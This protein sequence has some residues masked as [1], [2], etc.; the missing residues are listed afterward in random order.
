[1]SSVG[2]LF[3]VFLRLGNTSFGGPVAHIA[4][5]RDEFVERRRWFD[6]AEFADLVALCH[7][8]PGPASSQVVIGIGLQRAGMAGALAASLGFT[9]PSLVLMIAFGYGLLAAGGGVEGAAWIHALKVV[10]SAVIAQAIWAMA[11][12]LCPDR[13]RATLAMAAATT[14]LVWPGSVTQLLVLGA[15]GLFGWRWCRMNGQSGPAATTAT[16]PS[17]MAL[18]SLLLFVLLLLASLLVPWQDGGGPALSAAMFQTGALVFGGGHVVLPLL[19][20]ETVRTGWVSQ[21]AFLAGYGAAQALPGPLFTFAAFLGVVQQPSPNGLAGALLATFGIFL[22]SFLL[23]FAAMPYWRVLRG[24]ASARSAL[25]GVNAAVVG[26]L[27]AVFFD[28]VLSNAITSGRDV[29][30]GL[31]TFALLVFWKWPPWLVVTGAALLG[32]VAPGL[33]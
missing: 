16:V 25:A 24:N 23:I 11:R 28:P 19:E 6:D 4:Y 9:L 12:T 29:A 20:A 1:V 14:L 27:I 32:L 30:L 10:A 26:L 2:K 13:L 5:F 8:L 15:G 3:L 33:F 21:D 31:V 17:S 7:F 18:G 22:P